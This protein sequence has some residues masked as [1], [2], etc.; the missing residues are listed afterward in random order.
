MCSNKDS[1]QPKIKT[2][3][4]MMIIFLILFSSYVVFLNL[5]V[6]LCFLGVHWASCMCALFHHMSSISSLPKWTAMWAALEEPWASSHPQA[7]PR[8]M[9]SASVSGGWS[10]RNHPESSTKKLGGSSLNQASTLRF[11]IS[12]AAS[13]HVH[14]GIGQGVGCAGGG[15]RGSA[16]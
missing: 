16:V 12:S 6:Y 9:K 14:S 5:I 11:Y 10:P 15:Y 2:L 4:M 13:P 8:T 3:I 7:Q 1:V